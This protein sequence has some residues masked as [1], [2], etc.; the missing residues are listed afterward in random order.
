MSYGYLR[1]LKGYF[2]GVSALAALGVL[3]TPTTGHAIFTRC[4]NVST[5]GGYAV[6][7]EAV[8]DCCT[9]VPEGDQGRQIKE[10]L[11]RFLK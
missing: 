8:G 3:T 4:D 9:D 7:V 11:T 2:C 6:N 1:K 10:A 5:E